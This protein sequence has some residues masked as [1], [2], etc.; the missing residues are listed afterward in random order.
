M[1]LSRT[2]SIVL[3]VAATVVVNLAIYL[4]A[5][6]AGASFRF[7]GADGADIAWFVVAIFSAV[8]IGLALTAVALLAPRW[9]WVIPAALIAAPVVA[10]VSIP[11][12]PMP[13]GFDAGTTLGLALMHVATGLFAVLGV[14]GI[15]RAL[16]AS[17]P[18]PAAAR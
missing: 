9:R 6:G 18:A 15:R 5:G 2:A 12:M 11:L 1:R 8:P 14:L 7:P 10:L 4:V 13:V 3:A 17:E 16:G